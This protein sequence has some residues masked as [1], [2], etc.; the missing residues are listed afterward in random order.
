M[1]EELDETTGRL[2]TMQIVAPSGAVTSAAAQL[3]QD[4]AALRLGVSSASTPDAAAV[5]ILD[6]LDPRPPGATA[7]VTALEVFCD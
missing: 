3:L 7:L 2:Q 5:V 6:Y 4:V 1:L